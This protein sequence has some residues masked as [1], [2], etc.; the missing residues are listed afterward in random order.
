MSKHE[1]WLDE[2]H[3]WLLAKDSDSFGELFRN[4]QYE[5]HPPLWNILLFGVSR[6][7]DSFVGMQ[8]LH[9]LFA[10]GTVFLILRYAPLP[11]WVKV[12]LPFTYFFGFEYAI[13]ARNYAPAV[14]FIIL[15]CAWSQDVQRNV[16]RIAL[17]L[18]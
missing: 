4:M 18:G 7:T 15:A 17:V 8:I 1:I 13:I 14:F 3:H 12:L 11:F 9:L 5:G 6:V 16:Y 2:A 10:G